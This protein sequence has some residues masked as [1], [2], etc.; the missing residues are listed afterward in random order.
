MKKL[1]MIKI[2]LLVSWMLAF[3]E[4]FAQ[5]EYMEPMPTPRA[6]STSAFLN[7]KIYVIGGALTR[8]SDA[9]ATVEA[10]DP[11]INAW[12]TSIADLPV[13][14]CGATSQVVDEILY[15][16]GGANKYVGN[17]SSIEYQTVFAYN[18]DSNKWVQKHD[19]P[20]K[21][22]WHATDVNAG[23]IY[24]MGGTFDRVAR[25]DVY[26]FDSDL[27]VWEEQPSM[28]TASA[29]L[30][31]EGIDENIYA[32]GGMNQGEPKN[33]VEV[34]DS[35]SMYWKSKATLLQPIFHHGSGKLDNQIYVFGGIQSVIPPVFS[36]SM[37]LYNPL[38]DNWLDLEMD[39]P[40][41]LAGFTHVTAPDA[42]AKQCIYV[43]GGGGQSFWTGNDPATNSLLKFAPER[44]TEWKY[45]TPMPTPRALTASAVLNGKIYV[46]GGTNSKTSQATTKVEAYDMGT[47]TWDTNIAELPVPLCNH[48]AET[49][50]GKIYV[51]GGSDYFL[52]PGK[53]TTFE[54]D[55]S[56]NTW[57]AMKDAE[58]GMSGLSSTTVLNWIIAVG[59]IGE[60]GI[61]SDAV[62]IFRPTQ[63]RWDTFP[64]MPN[65]RAFSSTVTISHE[66]HAILVMGGLYREEL[67][68]EMNMHG[69]FGTWGNQE[70]MPFARYWH[71]AGV[72]H[73][74]DYV[75]VY[76]GIGEGEKPLFDISRYD[77]RNKSWEVIGDPLPEYSSP[78]ASAVVKEDTSVC[79]YAIGGP[80]YDFWNEGNGPHVTSL[81]LKYCISSIGT[82]VEDLTSLK[83][84]GTLSQNFPNPAQNQTYIPFE[85]LNAA[86][87]TIDLVNLEGKQMATIYSGQLNSG[88]HTVSMSAENIPSGVY[89]YRLKTKDGIAVKKLIVQHHD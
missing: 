76:G 48:T 12:D 55:P 15:V 86:F 65:K 77:W 61:A 33:E 26:M 32:M 78:F 44:H 5:W 40:E 7:G 21:R 6:L 59:G 28:P 4:C 58:V 57:A 67:V 46:I 88:K 38:D 52:G 63:N 22:A 53:K 56:A 39:M 31:T 79:F 45:M 8:F 80:T 42:T 24:L 20:S 49:I 2:L 13:P 85:L 36:E 68:S 87:V 72:I 16:I 3:F 75:Y 41:T 1:T 43:I 27:N 25:D 47:N 29:F 71:G 81:N 51:L 9:L 10:Y 69:G 18:L 34:F 30:A 60:E 64:P 23:K 17:T 50:Q 54:Y 35:D 37:L 73:P 70:E 11:K 82:H 14:L 66:V 74:I 19:I 89:L 62:S 83:G 84:T